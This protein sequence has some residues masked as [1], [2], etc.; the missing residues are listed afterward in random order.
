MP[1]LRIAILE[2]LQ[3][4]I[5]GYHFRLGHRPEFDIVFAA[6]SG[7]EFEAQLQTQPVDVA[8]IDLGVPAAPNDPQRYWL[9]AALPRLRRWR[10]GLAVLVVSIEVNPIIVQMLITAGINGYL[11]KQDAAA[12]DDLPNILQTVA[13]RDLYL[14]ATA[15]QSLRQ[16]SPAANPLSPRQQEILALLNANPNYSQEEVA[17]ALGLTASTVRNQMSEIYDRLEVRTRQAAMEEARRR[18]LI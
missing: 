11:V 12:Y 2:D 16:A 10:P 7:S 13:R 8:V 14:S 1:P 9:P 18:G 3:G 4:T 5:D 6:R 17:R 15:Q